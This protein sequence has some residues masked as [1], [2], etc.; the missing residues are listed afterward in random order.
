MQIKLFTIPIGDSGEILEEM[1]RFL[2]GNKILEIEN[3]L[4]NNENGVYWC[5]CIRYIEKTS[6]FTG[7][8]KVKKVDYKNILDEA[9]FQKFAK[10]REI[11]KKV[12][13]FAKNFILERMLVIKRGKA[14]MIRSKDKLE[15]KFYCQE[16]IGCGWNTVGANYCMHVE[17]KLSFET[18]NSVLER[19]LRLKFCTTIEERNSSS[20]AEKNS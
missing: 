8:T 6:G 17:L 1:N 12:A 7:Q 16:H 14:M 5:F 2:R 11:R 3:H 10:L 20:S 9:T 15:W 19:T 4:I 13:L 18:N